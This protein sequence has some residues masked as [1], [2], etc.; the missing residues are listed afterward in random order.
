MKILRK[1]YEFFAKPF[2]EDFIFLFIMVLLVCG[3][4]FVFDSYMRYQG[5]SILIWET[6][7][8]YL[9][10][11][12]VAIALQLLPT[13][14]KQLYQSVLLTLAFID[15]CIETSCII[16][17]K[18]PFNI[19]H[20]AIVMGTNLSELKEFISA[21]IIST[22]LWIILSAIIVICLFQC[23]S[24]CI[25]H[26]GKKIALAT[27]LISVCI[28][29]F[30]V[31]KESESWGY[32]FYNKIFAFISF[33][34][35]PDMR[36]YQIPLD[37]RV[38]GLNMPDNIVLILGE[39]FSK[40]HSSM[41]GYEKDT[42]PCL[43][44]MA[45]DSLLISYS[46]VIAP[47][48]HTIDCIKSIMSTYRMEYKDSIKWYECTTLPNIMKHCGYATYWVSN[49]SPSGVFDNIAARYSELCD[50]ALFVGNTMKGNDKTDL[51]EYIIPK[52]KDF[53]FLGGQ[54]L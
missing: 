2:K 25:N 8:S 23:G 33:E 38:A 31:S 5:L 12:F 19:E 52:L 15:F 11:Y 43:T 53:V 29:V 40:S 39:S 6:A 28:C 22:P 36:P 41:Y 4:R 14:L 24:K 18:N 7:H 50:T 21:Q 30:F 17:T 47:A 1:V 42:N 26:F 54:N 34:T 49:Q 16:V 37:I 51:D 27:T 9:L 20:V 48:T 10:C 3:P 46:D 35:P 44:A 45:K 13:K 32:K